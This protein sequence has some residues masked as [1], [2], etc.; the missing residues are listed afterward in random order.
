MFLR[1]I[2]EIEGYPPRACIVIEVTDTGARLALDDAG[3]VPRFFVL[4]IPT[5]KLQRECVLIHRH[6]D[7]TIGVQFLDKKPW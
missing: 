4:I 6:G 2:I 3:V 5:R 7:D 1:A